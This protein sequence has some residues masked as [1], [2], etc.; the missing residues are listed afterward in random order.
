MDLVSSRSGGVSIRRC[1]N[2][3]VSVTLVSTDYSHYEKGPRHRIHWD[4][5]NDPEVLAIGPQPEMKRERLIKILVGKDCPFAHTR[6]ELQAGSMTN[7][8]GVTDN[9]TEQQGTSFLF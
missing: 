9:F 8:P 7:I 5:I 3:P 4:E 2:S 1:R 6:W